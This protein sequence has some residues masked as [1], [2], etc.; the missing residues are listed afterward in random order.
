VKTPEVAR[1]LP[2]DPRFELAFEERPIDPSRAR[3][4]AGL[5]ALGERGG[6][7]FGSAYALAVRFVSSRLESLEDSSAERRFKQRPEPARS[8]DRPPA[9]AARAPQSFPPASFPAAR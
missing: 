4:L 8:A 2:S 7:A 9:P 3:L 1:P 6:A 5:K